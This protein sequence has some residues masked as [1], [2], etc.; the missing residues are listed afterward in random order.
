MA[1]KASFDGAVSMKMVRTRVRWYIGLLLIAIGFSRMPFS[2]IS[3]AFV[4][5]LGAYIPGSLLWLFFGRLMTGR[6][7]MP[8]TTFGISTKTFSAMLL[9][10]GSLLSVLWLFIDQTLA[11]TFT[12]VI[13]LGGTDVIL[14]LRNDETPNA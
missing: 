14:Q 12:L 8:A 11:A 9:T 1:G 4:F 13:A 6:K 3:D 10:G 2:N 7:D 5:A